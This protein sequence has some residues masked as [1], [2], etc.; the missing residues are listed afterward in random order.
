MTSRVR[1][2]TKVLTAPAV[3]LTTMF[4]NMRE[5]F[6]SFNIDVEWATEE[7]LNLPVLNVVDVGPC[8]RG[9]TTSEQNQLFTN[10]N[11][12][13]AND[14]VAYFV[15]ATDP[16]LN[17]CA[18]HPAGTPGAVV[19]RP[20]TQWTFAH[21]IGHVLDLIHFNNNNLL[22]TGNGTANITNPPP[23]LGASEGATMQASVLTVDVNSNEDA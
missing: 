12:A 1:V 14:I 11:F 8:V 18:A 20:A 15:L 16:P 19:V 10:R 22:M 4:Q 5:V 9:Q 2:H 17:G 21:E 3:P 7:P 23:D 6:A 13:D